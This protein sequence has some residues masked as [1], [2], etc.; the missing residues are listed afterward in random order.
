MSGTVRTQ[1]GWQVNLAL[2]SLVIGVVT[3]ALWLSYQLGQLTTKVESNIT[4]I[5]ALEA[6]DRART[7]DER[8][9]DERGARIEAKLDQIAPDHR[10]EAR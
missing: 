3:Q 7:I 4:R 2:V 1:G 8:R 9:R 6:V 5:V 10:E